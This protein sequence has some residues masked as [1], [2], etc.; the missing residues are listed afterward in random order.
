L[1]EGSPEGHPPC[2]GCGNIGYSVQEWVGEEQTQLW[3]CSSQS[4]HCRV[5]TYRP[6][7]IDPQD[8][9]LI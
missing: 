4:E 6:R 3:K 7:E 1:I 5:E 8:K 9:P 2:P